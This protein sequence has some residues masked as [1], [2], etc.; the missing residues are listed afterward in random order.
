MKELGHVPVVSV[1]W[2]ISRRHQHGADDGCVQED[3]DAEAKTD[4][5][6]HDEVAHGEAAEHRDHDQGC[7]GDQSPRGAQAEGYGVGIV[8]GRR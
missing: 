1:R 7:A 5:L 3:G 4:L 6:E 8:A 2:P